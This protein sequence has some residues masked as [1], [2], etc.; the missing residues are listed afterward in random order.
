MLQI[1]T[2]YVKINNGSDTKTEEGPTPVYGSGAESFK[3]CVEYKE[4]PTVLIGRKGATLHIPHFI[5]GNYWNVDTAFDVK[6]K[7]SSFELKYYYYCATAFDYKFYLTSTTLPSMT[8]TNY[9][10][11]FIPVPDNCYQK[12]KIV[13]SKISASSSG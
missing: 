4:G 11:M 1:F 6:L 13:S 9:G 8:Q 5:E 10:N 3:T 12:E 7:S 2:Y